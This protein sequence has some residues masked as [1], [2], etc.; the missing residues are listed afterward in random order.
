MYYD[1]ESGISNF[2]AGLIAGAILGAGIALL[3]APQTGKT[4]R[5]RI[6]HLGHD[7]P[8]LESIDED[9][10]DDEDQDEDAAQ[11]RHELLRALKRRRRKARQ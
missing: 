1:E 5:A 4:M 7:D 3:T 11:E 2:M 10:D 6:V 8:E 9:I